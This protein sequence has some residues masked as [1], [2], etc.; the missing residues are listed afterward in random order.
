MTQI[1]TIT[2]PKQSF[3]YGEE[4]KSLQVRHDQEGQYFYNRLEDILHAFDGAKQFG[5]GEFRVG[6][7]PIPFLVSDNGQR[8][9]TSLRLA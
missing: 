8:Y 6:G 9:R 1:I 2:A 4:T 7:E 5:V 3:M